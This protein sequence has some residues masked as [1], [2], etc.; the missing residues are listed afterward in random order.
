MQPA[1]EPGMCLGACGLPLV[2]LQPQ[3]F[4]CPQKFLILGKNH[5]LPDEGEDRDSAWECDRDDVGDN[6]MNGL[7]PCIRRENVFEI[8]MLSGK[9]FPLPS[10]LNKLQAVFSSFMKE[11][12]VVIL[13]MLICCQILKVIFLCAYSSCQTNPCVLSTYCVQGMER[14]FQCPLKNF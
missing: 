11:G 6:R 12:K 13:K 9:C 3:A 1:V 2:P 7:E 5:R 8:S 4:V 14:A 10:S